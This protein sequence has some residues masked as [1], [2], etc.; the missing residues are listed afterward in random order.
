MRAAVTVVAL[1]TVLLA[2]CTKDPSWNF[3]HYVLSPVPPSVTNLRVYRIG[4][5]WGESTLMFAFEATP[6]DL[7]KIR[8]SR[9]FYEIHPEKSGGAQLETPRLWLKMAESAG[10]A[11][12]EATRYFGCAAKDEPCA[13]YLFIGADGR[14]ARFIRFRY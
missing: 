7:E 11:P 5:S 3:A 2:A 6:F 9:D 1:A 12:M 8:S 4:H 10:F 13:Y 14:S